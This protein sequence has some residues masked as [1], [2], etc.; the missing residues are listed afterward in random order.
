MERKY[1]VRALGLAVVS[2][3]LLGAVSAAS[4]DIVMETVSVGNPGNA[5][6]TAEGGC[7]TA[8]VQHYGQVNYAYNIGK[9]DVTAFLHAVAATDT[10]SSTTRPW[11]TPQSAAE[12]REEGTPEATRTPSIR[13]SLTVW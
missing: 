6:N 9:Y 1:V 7:F 5:A 2:C 12:S 3:A 10:Y 11:R 8:G 4:A 13:P